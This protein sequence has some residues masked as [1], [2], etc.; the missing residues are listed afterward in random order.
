VQ[1]VAKPPAVVVP[2]ATG[3]RITIGGFAALTGAGETTDAQSVAASRAYFAWLNAHGGVYGHRIVYRVLD[4]HG[5]AK[6]VPS[7]AH[8]LVDQDAVFALFDVAGAAEDRAAGL[9]LNAARVPDVF[10]GAGCP[11]AN[12]PATQPY[13][14]GWQLDSVREGKILGTYITRR[15]SGEKVGVLFENDKYGQGGVT[16]LAAEISRPA[17][18]AARS[19]EADASSVSAQLASLKARGARVVV[20]FVGPALAA[21]LPR[22]LKGLAF[23]PEL[24][25]SDAGETLPDGAITDSFLPAPASAPRSSAGSWVALFRRVAKRYLPHAPFG[26]SA[27]YGMAAAYTFAEAMIKAGPHVTRQGLVAAITSGLPQG[28]AVAPLVFSASDHS[29]ATGAY[30]GVIRNGVLVP[31]GGVMT[32]GDAPTSPVVPYSAAAPSAPATGTPP[33]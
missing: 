31:L 1:Q 24:V 6:A 27:M 11:C 10:A 12:S 20:A 17:M 32:T 22:A 18:V 8:Q 2:G 19:A 13:T 9:L 29:G 3:S 28:P 14:F 5:D 16:G 21:Q 26:A 7:L 4:D 25:V 33:G 23:H 15:F 30:V